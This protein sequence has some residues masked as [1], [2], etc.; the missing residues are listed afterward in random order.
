[1]KRKIL[2]IS[3]VI[4]FI[5]LAVFGF[6]F[7]HASSNSYVGLCVAALGGSTGF[8][9]HGNLAAAYFHMNAFRSFS[10][11]L[12]AALTA[13]FILIAA[14]LIFSS[15]L[16]LER[17][18]AAISAFWIPATSTTSLFALA[19]PLARWFTLREREAAASA[20]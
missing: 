8:C 13:F 9:P 7:M 10:N 5:A 18:E 14:L 6:L 4:S 1:M 17:R 12:P 3:L 11:I 20:F 19:A 16:G 15:S 2:A